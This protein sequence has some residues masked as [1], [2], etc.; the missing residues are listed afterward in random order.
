MDKR[1]RLSRFYDD[2]ELDE[3]I[4]LTPEEGDIFDSFEWEVL[5]NNGLK[6]ISGGYSKVTILDGDE[7]IINV[8]VECGK[9][10]MGDGES[11]CDRWQ[12]EYDR[13]TKKFE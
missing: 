5:C 9:E 6:N 2:K 11:S 4:N 7:E 12:V 13:E 3:D 1:E 10:N 8:E